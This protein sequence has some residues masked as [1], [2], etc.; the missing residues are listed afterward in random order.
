MNYFQRKSIC[1]LGCVVCVQHFTKT[2][3]HFNVGID[4]HELYNN[5]QQYFYKILFF[6]LLNFIIKLQQPSV[7]H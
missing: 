4:F 2:F 5:W 3:D 7:F 1:L 6:V